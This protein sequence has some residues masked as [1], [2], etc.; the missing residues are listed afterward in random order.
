MAH[1]KSKKSTIDWPMTIVTTLKANLMAYLVT[2]IFIILG[3]MILTY[4]NFGPGFEKWIVLIGIVLSAFLA[5]F[6]TAKVEPR[7]GY[8][9]GSIGGSVYLLLFLVMA[10]VVNG[11]SGLDLGYILTVA[12]L[13]LVSSAI[14]GMVSVNTQK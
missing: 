5:G 2:A 14:A 9:W 12:V 3:S 6:D 10:V 4:T 8:K 13:V 11:V 7:N 1:H